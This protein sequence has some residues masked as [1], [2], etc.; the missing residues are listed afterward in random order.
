MSK[1]KVVSHIACGAPVGRFVM[2]QS[3]LLLGASLAVFFCS[4]TLRAQE[5][6]M[7][8]RHD[9][10]EKLGRVNF[11][12]SCKKEAQQQFNRAVALLHSF[13]Y[14]EA[15]KAFTEVTKTDSKC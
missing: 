6:P 13:W 15:E 11:T 12:V 9:P 4:L 14:D 7:P 3:R 8:H 5:M 2:K 1:L 10:G